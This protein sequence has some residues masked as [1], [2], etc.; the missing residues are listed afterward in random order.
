MVCGCTNDSPGCKLRASHT[1]R[2]GCACCLAANPSVA[3]VVLVTPCAAG[4]EPGTGVGL[5]EGDG[6]AVG[7]GDAA[8]GVGEGAVAALLQAT[9]ARTIATT[10]TIR[11]T[12]AL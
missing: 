5:G 3:S 8:A 2:N 7:E 9:A 10:G 4:S 11:A 12:R 1:P 6:L